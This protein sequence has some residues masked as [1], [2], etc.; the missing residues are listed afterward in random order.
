MKQYETP[1][2]W[3]KR[4]ILAS[5]IIFILFTILGGIL[6]DFIQIDYKIQP[7]I[8]ETGVIGSLMYFQHNFTM[9]LFP[10]LGIFLFGI[11]SIVHIIFNSLMLGIS[12]II[13]FNHGMSI[14]EIFIRLSQ[15][16]FE[17]PATIISGAIGLLGI[18]FYFQKNKK[19]WLVFIGKWTLVV[20]F[21]LLLAGIME[22]NITK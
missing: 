1:T 10:I 7:N 15:G 16:I 20:A 14:S 21:L 18:N 11:T 4:Y 22:A 19:K 17:I 2:I 5:T 9:A 8:N 3:F 12:V 13:S 6:G